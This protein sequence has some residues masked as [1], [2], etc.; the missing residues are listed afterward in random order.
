M[1]GAPGCLFAG[2]ASMLIS[3]PSDYQ[4]NCSIADVINRDPVTKDLLKVLFWKITGFL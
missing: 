1:T 2:K 4:I 3:L